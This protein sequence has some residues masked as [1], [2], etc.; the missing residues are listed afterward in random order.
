MVLGQ[1]TWKGESLR[2]GELP[3]TEAQGHHPEGGRS[4]ALPGER[5]IDL[6]YSVRSYYLPFVYGK[7]VTEKFSGLPPVY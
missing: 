4:R 3:G 5:G 6:H 7:K 2:A 1:V